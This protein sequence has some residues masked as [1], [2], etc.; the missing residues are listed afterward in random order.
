MGETA[1][2]RVDFA[3]TL[4]ELDVDMVPMNFLNPIPGTPFEK[5]D[6][7]KPIEILKCIACFRLILPKKEIMIAGG[8]VANLRDVQSMIYF[9]GA[10][11]VMVGNYL[12]TVNQPVEKD[13]QLIHDLGLEPAGSTYQF[14]QV[15]STIRA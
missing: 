4:K 9:A 12:T 2:D 14:D 7:M 10:S 15:R 5:C 1:E 13:L 6:P 3:F 11:A 8:R